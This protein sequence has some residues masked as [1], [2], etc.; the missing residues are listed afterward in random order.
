[1]ARYER[2][3]TKAEWIPRTELGRR[4]KSGEIA[5]FEQLYEKGIKVLEP[6]V[7][8]ALI[9]ELHEEVLEVT[10]TQ[11]MTAYGRKQQMRAVIVIGD[12]KGYVG[13]GVGKAAD[14][15]D[16]IAE[17]ITDA[18]K[19]ITRVQLGCASWECNCGTPHTV[20]R[21]ATGQNSST[22][23]TLKPAPRGVG[24]VANQTAKKVLQLAGVK[25]VWTFTK[26][27]TRNILNMALATVDAI[28]SINALKTIKSET[29]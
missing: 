15:R 7:I 6:Q 3:Q 23:I 28:N 5:S 22:E 10:S 14:S 4:V 17:A 27:R 25:D 12:G 1:M 16:A 24:I 29:Q 19:N 9:P 18:K 2:E 21:E 26:G 20:V 8:D 13:V 11:R